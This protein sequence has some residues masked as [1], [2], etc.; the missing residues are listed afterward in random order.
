MSLV[1]VGT[2]LAPR[3]T[4]EC[5]RGR[6]ISELSNL[7]QPRRGT[8]HIIRTERAETTRGGGGDLELDLRD[9]NQTASGRERG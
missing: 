7:F 9:P 1:V 2:L 4:Q 3:E 5:F 8:S 6:L